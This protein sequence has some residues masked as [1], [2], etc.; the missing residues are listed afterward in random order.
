LQRLYLWRTP[1]SPEAV[2]A[3]QAKWPECEIVTG[4]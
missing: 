1:V 2:A 4:S 3:L